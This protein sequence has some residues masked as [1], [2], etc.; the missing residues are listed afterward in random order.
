MAVNCKMEKRVQELTT[1]I[2]IGLSELSRPELTLLTNQYRLT[3]DTHRL[4][5]K[6][7]YESESKRPMYHYEVILKSTE[8]RDDK[9]GI[10]PGISKQMISVDESAVDVDQKSKKI[11]EMPGTAPALLRTPNKHT[12]KPKADKKA[13]DNKT[14]KEIQKSV[15]SQDLSYTES[16]N[17]VHPMV[18]LSN[19]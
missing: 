15:Q 18:K 10:S 11:T 16:S 1:R 5:R 2:E 3:K 8:Q 17:R 19:R 9:V 12:P 13:R 6:V 4:I 7:T 14:I